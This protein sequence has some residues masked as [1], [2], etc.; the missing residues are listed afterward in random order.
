MADFENNVQDMADLESNDQDVEKTVEDEEYFEWGDDDCFYKV[1]AN[2]ESNDQDVE[3]TVED[4]EY[5]EW[6]DDDSF[7]KS[8]AKTL[9]NYERAPKLARFKNEVRLEDVVRDN[10]LH[11][12]PAKSLC[13]FKTVSRGWDQWLSS[14]LFAHRQTTHFKDIS[15][16]I[17]QVP[18]RNPSFISFDRKAYGVPDPSLNFLPE[19]VNIRTS[20]NG[21]LCCQSVGD[22]V[23]YICNPV[24]KSWKSLP[25]SNLYHGPEAAMVLAFEPNPL[26][27]NESYEIVCAVTSPD[28]L[29]VR[30]EIY[31]SRSSSWRTCDAICC[32]LGDMV[33]L[34]GY[35]MNG[36]VYWESSSGAVIVFHLTYEQYGI[37]PLPLDV[38][39]H[40][41]L[42]TMHGELCYILPRIEDDHCTVYIHGNMDMSLKSVINL[43]LDDVMGTFEVCRA[44]ASINDDI[45]ILALDSNV[46]A[47]HVRE[48]KA[49]LIDTLTGAACARFLPYVNN[50]ALARHPLVADIA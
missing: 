19:P 1:M 2:L 39:H 27:F 13:R 45:L 21:L 35:Y 24:T 18:G 11:L 36:V 41:S 30:F 3:K 46:I 4:E 10:A 29:I 14:P 15:G 23:Y 50:L 43:T 12:L 8:T 42:S 17:C 20:C 25:R 31:S 9:E 47:F 40:G 5:F 26:H 6:G 38:G 28:H 33:L 22:N 44:L 16:L 34:N 7:Y 32:E 48:Q 37:L 49:E